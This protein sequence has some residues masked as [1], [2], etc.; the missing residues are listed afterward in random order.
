MRAVTNRS[1]DALC[2]AVRVCVLPFLTLLVFVFPVAVIL[3]VML[4]GSW[5]GRAPAF[6]SVPGIGVVMLLGALAGRATDKCFLV[7][8]TGDPCDDAW[9]SWRFALVG[10]VLIAIGVLVF[11]VR[12]VRASR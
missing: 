1:L 11:L 5:H 12:E 4:A 6:G 3:T 8:G 2:F 10:I 9:H 7:R